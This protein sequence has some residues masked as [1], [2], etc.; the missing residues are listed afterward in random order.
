MEFAL[1]SAYTRSRNP[2]GAAAR[3][4]KNV[5]TH[6]S[7]E[8]E[9]EKEM[10]VYARVGKRNRAL[11]INNLGTWHDVLLWRAKLSKCAR[12]AIII[13]NEPKHSSNFYNLS[14]CNLS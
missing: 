6:N 12:H 10:S 4:P 1:E 7:S 2:R 8:L 14:L 13:R 3:A 11:I 5:L 9:R